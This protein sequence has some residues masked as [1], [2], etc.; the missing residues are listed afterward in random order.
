MKIF[1]SSLLF[2]LLCINTT[3]T[4]AEISQS[5]IDAY[6]HKMV[7]EKA[8]FIGYPVNQNLDI[9]EF[10]SWFIDEGLT[11]LAMN[12]VG[13]P[14]S[15]SKYNLN[16]HR[17]ERDVIEFFANKYNFKKDSYWGFITQSGT[18]GNNH[19]LY[20]ARK[21]LESKSKKAPII[22]VSAD[23]H[24]SIIKLADVQNTEL[25]VVKTDIMGRMDISDFNKKVDPKRPAIVVVAI[26]TTFKGAID[27]HTKIL[28]SLKDHKMSDYYLHLDAALFG[29]YLPFLSDSNGIIDNARRYF[30]SISVSG[31]KF[32]GL[33]EPLGIFLMSKDKFQT[34]KPLR[35][36]YLEEAIPTISCSRSAIGPMKIWWKIFKSNNANFTAQAD[37]VLENAKYLEQ[38]MK[39]NGFKAY[40]NDHSNTVFF[41]SPARSVIDKYSL[42]TEKD[43]D[44]GAL[45]HIVVMQHVTKEKLDTFVKDMVAARA[46]K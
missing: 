24:Y 22:Y 14:F 23:A 27:D 42:A 10:Y 39:E 25:R 36:E 33:D 3:V 11:Q 2:A 41:S 34:I 17:F 12:N 40:R 28:A 4:K 45:S 9:K 29:G 31:H 7:S 30:D 1:A 18:D 5:E 32:F 16:T 6:S 38:K 35:V 37:F 44:L 21:H 15:K 43:T 26:G 8:Q 20:F 46:N 13:N 19:G